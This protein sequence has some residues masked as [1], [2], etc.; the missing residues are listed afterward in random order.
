MVTGNM[1]ICD[2][3]PLPKRRLSALFFIG[4]FGAGF[5]SSVVSALDWRLTPSLSASEVFSDNLTLSEN[6]KKSGFVSEVSPGLALYGTSPWSSFNLNY[7]L[8]G[9]YNA[10]GR[11]ALDINHQLNMN[12]LYQAVRNTL[13]LET[14]SSIS[15]QNISNSLLT[16]DNISGDGARNEVKTFSISPYWTPRFGRYANGLFRV[17][18]NRTSFDNGNAAVVSPLISNFISDSESYTRQARLS[19]G[20]AFNRISWGLNYSSQEQGRGSGQDVRF[21]QYQ[22]DARLYINRKFNVFGQAGFADNDYQT[23]SNNINNGFFY[24]VGG[25]W[26]PSR[27]YSLEAGYGNNKHVT[28]QFNPSAN[29]SSTITYRDKSVGLNT[30]SSWDANFNYRVQQAV[31]GFSYS[32][33]TT[34]LQQLLAEQGLFLRD[35]SGNLNQVMNTRDLI[36]QGYLAPDPN[37]PQRLL[38]G[39]NFNNSRL[40]FNPFDYVDDVIIRKHGN[41]SLSY[42]TGKSSYN[43][44]VFNERRTYER[45]PGEDT[46]YGVSGGWQWQYE[47]RLSFFLQPTWMHTEGSLASNTRYDVALGVSRAVPINL[48]RPLLMNTRLEFR[49]IN[50]M[51]DSDQFGYVENRATANFNVRF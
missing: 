5:Y 41:L 36:L 4:S 34:T 27:W 15:Q 20:S 13:F 18:Y 8:Q 42:Q 29:L 11:D 10:G 48:G 19:S 21:E 33:E 47:P 50:Q 49:H 9:L 45:R 1:D 35:A 32:Q 17:G 16:T 24:T 31:I 30:G 39:P 43:A 25:Q 40:V 26:S 37:N 46:S 44:S 22:G 28:L 51:S 7:R 3:I 6:N 12:S 14:S 23:L 2:Y 38:P